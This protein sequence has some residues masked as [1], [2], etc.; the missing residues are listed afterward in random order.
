MVLEDG[1][2]NKGGP[3]MAFSIIGNGN[4]PKF[5]R[6][7]EIVHAIKDSLNYLGMFFTCFLLAIS[8]YKDRLTW[9]YMIVLA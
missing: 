8:R 9:V 3:L 4:N 7:L 5:C 6:L 2:D 1:H